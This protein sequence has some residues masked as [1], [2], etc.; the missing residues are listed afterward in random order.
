MV[1]GAGFASGREI[2]DYFLMYGNRWRFGVIISGVLFFLL[3]AAVTDIINQNGICTYKDYLNTVMGEKQAVFTEWVSGLFFFAMFFAMTSAAG[4]AAGEMLGLDYKIGSA[5]LL[6]ICAVVMLKGMGAIESLSLLLVPLLSAGI[7][8]IG[9]KAGNGGNL[10]RSG[11]SAALSAVIYVSY[12]TISSASVIVQAEKSKSRLDGIITGLLCGAAMTLMG[13]AIGNAV[14]AGGEEAIGA[15]LPFALVSKS[16]GRGY[17][18]AYGAV[19]LASVLT[20]AICDG[21]AAVAFLEEKT[22][23]GRIGAVIVL[24]ASAAVFASVSFSDFVSKIYPIFGI[25]GVLQL[26]NT[27]L[28]YI[29]KK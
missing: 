14:L 8:I 1:V 5:A 27:L 17:F 24:T 15:E 25:A 11:G 12:N 10:N 13:F 6:F 9:A 23:I 26:L 2:T 3:F 29:K 7:C 21:T 16:L 22:H 19:F 20:T 4:S 18:F 28:F